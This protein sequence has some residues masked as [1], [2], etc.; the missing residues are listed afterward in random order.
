MICKCGKEMEL[1]IQEI[2]DVGYG[3]YCYD[4]GIV[5]ITEMRSIRKEG[6]VWD[7]WEET[8]KW[9]IPKTSKFKESTE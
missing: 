7:T 8:V 3:Y 5:A 2:D 4:C 9:L 6:S 1:E